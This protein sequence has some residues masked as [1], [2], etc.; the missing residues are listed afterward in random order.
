MRHLAMDQH[1]NKKVEIPDTA[2]WRQMKADVT[3]IVGRHLDVRGPMELIDVVHR[4]LVTRVDPRLLKHAEYEKIG[5]LLSRWIVDTFHVGRGGITAKQ[6]VLRVWSHVAANMPDTS[7]ND[8]VEV[9]IE[10][11]D[12]TRIYEHLEQVMQTA[13]SPGNVPMAVRRRPARPWSGRY[14]GHR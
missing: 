14:H 3:E 6:D 2:A 7:G 9:V 1:E 4:E 5:W 10:L 12:G 8:S 11:G 13:L